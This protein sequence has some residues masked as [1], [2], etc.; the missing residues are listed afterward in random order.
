VK[1]DRAVVVQAMIDE[2]A[3][4]IF[5]S[6]VAI[7]HAMGACVIAEGIETVEA[8]D[9][10]RRDVMLGWQRDTGIRGVQG[11]LLGRPAH[12]P[13]SVTNFDSHT[14]F[15]RPDSGFMKPARIGRRR[16]LQTS[17]RKVSHLRNVPQRLPLQ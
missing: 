15:T 13:W 8:F 12:A 6:I 16:A 11:Y 9:F 10:V 14:V 3:R 4:A 1:I 2:T 7:A 17:L 5:A